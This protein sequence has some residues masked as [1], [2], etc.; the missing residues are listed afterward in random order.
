[1]TTLSERRTAPHEVR[2]TRVAIATGASAER[3][4]E[5][6]AHEDLL[7]ADISRRLYD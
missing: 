7:R 5:L 1:M 4:T 6:V 2:V 3:A